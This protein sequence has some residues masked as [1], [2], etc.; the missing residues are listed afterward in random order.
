MNR[1][2]PT[3]LALAMVAAYPFSGALPLHAE[4]VVEL[5]PVVVT[6]PP[7]RAPLEVSFDPRAPQQPLPANDGAAL[8]KAIPGMSVIRKAGTD[9]DPVFRGMAA[10][11]L[12]IL[13]DG[14][15][16]LGGC[17][18]RMDPPTAYVFPDAYDEVTLMKGPQ[19]VLYGPGGSAGTV[20]FERRAPSFIEPGWAAA[21]AITGASFERHDEYADVKAGG[22]AGYVQAIATHA[23]AGD[24]EDGDGR[25]VHSR[26]ERHSATAV[27]GWTPDRDTRLEFSTIRSDGE[28]AYAD[29][30]M[31]GSAFDRTNYALKFDKS[32]MGGTLER[33]EALAYYNYIDHVMD[34]YSLR[35]PPASAAMRMAMNPDR[36][37]TGARAAFTLVP[38]E[39]TRLVVGADQESNVHTGRGSGMGGELVAPYGRQ[40]RR[41]DARFEQLGLFGELNRRLA[42]DERLVAG[43]R[44]DQWKA[45]DRRATIT[46]GTGMTAQTVSNPSAGRTRRET[47]GSGFLRY[48]RT[49]A[50]GATAYAGLG[51]AERAPDYWELFTKEGTAAITAFDS[52][53]PEKT[54]QL[55]AGVTWKS[56]A[57]QAYA[58]LFYGRIDDYILVQSRMAKTLP[59]RAATV[60]RNV[61]ATTRGGEAG[62]VYAFSSAWK[63]SASLAAA[64]GDNDTDGRPL[65][66]M[67]PLEG[68]LG[69][70][71]DNGRWSAGGLLRLVARQNRYA[72]NEGNVVGQDLG[73]AGGFAVISLNGG[74]RWS[75][76]TRIAF[77]VDNL[78]D[79][80][81]AEALSR[82]GDAVAIQGYDRTVRVNEPGRGF[83][84]KA[85][86]ALE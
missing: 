28:A 31:D 19:T 45:T 33:I 82:S 51:H 22:P 40:P 4:E 76:T 16:I 17:G 39:A 27:L 12:N 8:L 32:A 37:T 60:V 7:M 53:S 84:L 23:R 9:G 83:W 46:L 77:G 62:L 49:L 64:R 44:A 65:G 29:R 78:F 57:L 20:R 15:H 21:A 63:G 34:N 55:D 26:Y 70:D 2:H 85:Q 48:E 11:R 6:A 52:L 41:E 80:T 54:T 66:Q 61:D 38:D 72:L 56:A 75:K 35:T 1:Q 86:V 18:G 14:A 59:M 67:P 5:A 79:K 42:E 73:P 50:T 71:W 13:L 10:S 69:L 47:L 30:A 74:Y 24:Y 3:R 68:R 58:S 81:Y 36:K 25:P 43:L